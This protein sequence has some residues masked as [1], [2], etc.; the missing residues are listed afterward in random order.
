LLLLLLLFFLSARGSQQPFPPPPHITGELLTLQT[1]VEVQL[2]QSCC[3]EWLWSTVQLLA[4]NTIH[5]LL[6]NLGYIQGFQSRQEAECA[7]SVG[8][9]ECIMIRV[10]GTEHGALVIGKCGKENAAQKWF[11]MSGADLTD[12]ASIIGVVLG[13]K[14]PHVLGANGARLPKEPLAKYAPATP[15]TGYVHLLD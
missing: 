8:G 15:I 2:F 13:A 10:S 9:T 12:P 4:R 5:Q 6:W 14:A 3:W 11:K 7:L 1:L